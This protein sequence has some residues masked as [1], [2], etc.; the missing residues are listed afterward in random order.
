M[1]ATEPAAMQSATLSSLRRDASESLR[2]GDRDAAIK[3]AD[4]M[5]ADYGDNVQAMVEAGDVYLRSG[6]PDQAVVQFDRFIEKVPTQMPYL[7][8][9]GIALYFVG[10]YQAAAEQFA[11]HRAVNPH[12]VENAAWHF[13]CV[14]KADSPEKARQMLLPAPGDGREPMNEVLEMLSSGNTKSVRDRIN[15]VV[16]RAPESGAAED[17]KFYGELYLGLY[18]DALGDRDEA[19]ERMKA[20]SADAPR[21]Y[22]GDVGRVYADLLSE[23]MKSAK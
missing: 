7:W 12:D 5:V 18:A 19:I 1:L 9:R 17:A 3:A 23:R 14:A 8:Q 10:K 4:A 20:A 2:R 13:V 21:H 15:W 22:M 6:K 11:K 16:K